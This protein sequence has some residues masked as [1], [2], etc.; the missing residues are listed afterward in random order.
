MII[1]IFSLYRVGSQISHAAEM[2]V[3]WSRGSKTA[4][5]MVFTIRASKTQCC[6]QELLSMSPLVAHRRV[7]S[8][9]DNI[10]MFDI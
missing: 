9:I 1:V 8:H 5:K 3:P 2:A 10:Y 6:I 7:N 4:P